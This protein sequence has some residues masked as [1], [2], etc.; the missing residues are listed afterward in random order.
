MSDVPV[1]IPESYELVRTIST[2][3]MV[4]EHIVRHRTEDILLRLKIF[5]FTSASGATTRRHSREQLRSDITFM[6]ELEQPGIV[7][8]FD[9]SD[10]KN[11][12]WITTQ[13][14]EVD[15]LSEC[16]DFLVT[17]S[18]EFR[19]K[20][21]HQ[22]LTVL[23]CIH[24]RRVV[25][26][27][28]SGNAV[29]LT[30]K[31]EIYIGDFGLASHLTDR[32][33]TRMET[34]LATT[35]SY[36]PP[37][38]R[39][40]DTFIC[41]IN[42]D[43]FS[44]GLLTFEI[45]TATPLPQ[46]S[47]DQIIEILKVLLNEQVDNRIITSSTADVILKAANLSPENRW[48]TA[49]DFADALKASGQ[50]KSFYK[51]ASADQMMTMAITNSTEPV[52]QTSE[53]H[54]TEIAPQP[55]KPEEKAV[56]A[57]DTITPLDSSH[58]VWNN[59][60]E[61]LEKIGEG[62]QAVVYKAYDHLTNEEIAIKTI[63]SRHRKDRAAINRLKQGAM[64]A[65]SLTHRHIIKT[66]S[67][68]QRTD[69]D[70][71][72][73]YVFICMELVGSKLD[74][75][76]VIET[77]KNTGTKISLDE[78]LH[79]IHQL[80]D[81]LTYA[82]EY[83][84]H[85]DIK[86]ANIMLVPRGEHTENDI[87]DLT[88]FDI[89]L[90]DFGIAK[91][92]S[93]KHIDVTG[94]G[95]RS[96]Y[97]G[98]PELADTRTG[99]DAR[100]DIYSVGVIIYQMLT[101]N[102]PRKG[103]S[104]ANKVNKDVPAALAKVI[105]RSIST[106]REK[107]FKT[108]SE[109]T[110]EI[111]RAVSKFNWVRKA[112]KVAA[113]LLIIACTAAGIKYFLPEEERL[114]VQH[115]MT[116]LQNRSPEAEIASL[117][118]AAVR[119]SDIE[120]YK[121]YEDLRANALSNL[122]V[123]ENA[124]ND[125]F[126]K[127]F[128][129][130]R[131]QEEEWQ[132]IEPAIGKIERIAEDQQQYNARRE[133]LLIINHLKKLLPSSEIVSKVTERAQTAETL[134]ETRPIAQNT[135]DMCAESYYSAANVYVNIQKLA[136][137][138]DTRETA[139]RINLEFKNVGQLREASLFTRKA[140]E[141]I[142]QLNEYGFHERSTKCFNKADSCYNTFELQSATE[143]YNLLSQICGTMA[144]VQ[145]Q[146]DF[147]RSDIGLISTRL[148]DLCYED[149]KT[150]ENYPAWKEKLE[151]VYKNKDIAAKYTLIRGL[152]VK[153]PRDFPWEIYDLARSAL[154]QYRQNNLDSAAADLIEAIEQYK[155]FMHQQINKLMADCES[156][157]TFS[158]VPA[159]KINNCKNALEKLSNTI[160]DS[161]WPQ[162]DF[163]DEY[164]RYSQ[165]ILDEKKAVRKQLTEDAQR[166]RKSIINSKNKAQT[167]Q[168]L[169]FWES[170]LISKYIS[171]AQQYDNDEIEA[172]IADWKYVEDLS[173]LSVIINQMKTIDSLLDKMLV[174]KDQLDRLAADIDEATALCQRFKGI[175]SEEKEKYEQF[176]EDLKQLRLKLTA[177]QDN[178]F[179]IDQ[180]DE[181]FT[182]EYGIIES[183]FLEIHA[184]LPYHRNRVI[185]LI[186]KTHSLEQ[187][188]GDIGRLHQH[189]SAIFADSISLEYKSDFTQT[190]DYLESVK[191]DVDNWPPKRF[192]QQMRE[193]CNVL[194]DALHKQ[195]QMLALITSTITSEKLRLLKDIESFRIK[196]NEILSDEDIRTL[197]AL[198]AADDRQN[199]QQ[200]RQIPNLLEVTRQKLTTITLD[201]VPTSMDSLLESTSTD[202]EVDTWLVA[203]NKRDLQL[204]S[205]ILKLEAI[206]DAALTFQGIRELLA[207]QSSAKR[208]YYIGLR[209]YTVG[210]IDYSDVNSKIDAVATD[211][212]SVKMCKFLEQMEDDTVPGLTAI[213]TTVSE[214]TNELADLKTAKINTLTEAKDF[215]NKRLQ[216]LERITTL[217]RD[218]QKLDKSNIENTCK[219]AIV[220]AVDTIK[221]LI[222]SSSQADKLSK[223]TTSLW[224]FYPEHR[225]WEQW[226]AFL[227]LHHI[228]VSDEDILL[229]S[230]SFL[231]PVNENGDYLKL[232]EITAN[233]TKILNFSTANSSNFGWPYHVCHQKDPT[234]I[235]AFVPG[236]TSAGNG[237]FYMAIREI[238]NAQYILFLE[239]IGAKSPTN[240]AG[241]TYFTDESSNALIL[242]TQGQ[243]PPSRITWDKV[244]NTV[245]L[246]KNFENAPVTWV[247]S[248]GAGAYAKWFDAQLP[249]IAQYSYAARSGTNTRYPWGDE[250][251]DAASYA[252]VRST[253]W[254]NA[255][256]DYNSKRDDPV[257]IAYP[258]VGAVKDFL[259]GEAL[260]PSGIAHTE[261]ND[262]PV[263][264]YFTKNNKSNAWGLYDMLGNAWEW[265]I[266]KQNNSEAVICGGSCLCPPEYIS[267]DSKYEFKA[268][269]CDVGFRI[270]ITLN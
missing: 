85:R 144:Y 140:I 116:L 12:F 268:Q 187:Q 264:P 63:W 152:L 91:V 95:F 172:G 163:A 213:K 36:L 46:D 208:G 15:K 123:L 113:V 243:Y 159:E 114:P 9:Y 177:P 236:A 170:Q 269:A 24:N 134:L 203:F 169:F 107:R 58:E 262:Y 25:H 189:W 97:Y 164:N 38:V 246:D 93:Q 35:T 132:K 22:F 102:I 41:N 106:D 191:E 135:L 200:F 173:R 226:L 228:T 19:Q 270:V 260:E 89:K 255:A 171:V 215:N 7:R 248:N 182:A 202:F 239:K 184:K 11:Q 75:A 220:I 209:D 121:S 161:P 83:T 71:A 201:S 47:P 42:S 2:S 227:Q 30:P 259:R 232:P 108:I 146:I 136:G 199:L 94:K 98:A 128:T 59:H 4:S 225:D 192:N 241:W 112:A 66:Y 43:I 218:I 51:K 120:G 72:G 204:D 205:Q 265:C 222:V 1:T 5:S 87:S 90:I 55:S 206:Q 245:V 54:T 207:N 181:A 21:V 155:E 223:L 179:I 48:P 65:R 242:Q 158:T 101:R 197:E 34:T 133:N 62:G 44:A 145:D 50:D 162:S 122:K 254:Q 221:N 210:L 16:F 250:L 92:L 137:D 193:R 78:T 67:V 49:D 237:L 17:Q 115:S 84:I 212:A 249:T 224:K 60:Y 105:D 198:A 142:E 37:E 131:D 153:S 111:E 148:M 33:T 183:A 178:I 154:Q 80:L 211:S 77:R 247:T 257:K 28:I 6:E 233:P 147:S 76:H 70:S 127:N 100:A 149:V 103:S 235:F 238:T 157:S 96:A 230:F 31:H 156:L 126:D 57:V 117:A 174:R 138:S 240:M 74:L 14:A 186:K 219:E 88:K 124:G 165:Q 61:I 214:I 167:Q 216:L 45:L 196:V 73:K 151:H 23:Q 194:A 18:V 252:H 68:E 20:L 258:P 217:R 129:T 176:G 160:I 104:P 188:A 143:Y 32:P 168:Q 190:R 69:A 8:V 150:F 118:N 56:E 253:A 52:A 263:W 251:S 231:R 64:I 3:D 141:K 266:D 109:F 125:T 13:P 10:S 175:S 166:L 185:E 234:V 81:A 229:T 119:Y 26:R 27:N 29:F 130:W 261:N 139:E 53:D 86:P 82:H 267:P 40:A 256:R 180:A 99:V 244:A 39:G 110:K 79:I 195:V